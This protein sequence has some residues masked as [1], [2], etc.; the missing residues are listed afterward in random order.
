MRLYLI[1]DNID[2]QTGF[3]LAGVNGVVVHE[4]DEFI[5]A[6]D[7]ALNMKDIGIILITVKLSALA[8]DYINEIKLNR[9]L[10]LIVEIPDRHGLGKPE[11][12]ITGYVRDAIGLKI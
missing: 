3:R 9:S 8:T 12:Y 10:P 1:S 7:Y 4:R 2:T 11:D 5:K 6:L